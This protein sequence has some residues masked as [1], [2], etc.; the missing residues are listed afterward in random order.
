MKAV[1]YLLVSFFFLGCS[2]PSKIRTI[3]EIPTK[4]TAEDPLKGVELNINS[5]CGQSADL[6]ASNLLALNA[7]T[8]P[9]RV[10]IFCVESYYEGPGYEDNSKPA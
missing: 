1:A 6:R 8:H 5:H 7:R 4:I 10:V 9:S 2:I 3:V